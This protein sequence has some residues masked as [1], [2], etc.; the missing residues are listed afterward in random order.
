VCVESVDPR[1]GCRQA[2]DGNRY[3]LLMRGMV[4]YGLETEMESACKENKKGNS[5]Q[6][7]D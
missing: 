2:E 4:Q 6:I 1:G 3:T 5:S 7:L